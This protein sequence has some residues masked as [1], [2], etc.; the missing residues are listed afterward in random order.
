MP[1][2]QVNE[3]PRR[4]PGGLPALSRGDGQ[5]PA[6]GERLQQHLMGN[7][8]VLV[9]S[10]HRALEVLPGNLL[11]HCS[12]KGPFSGTSS[13]CMV[14]LAC[15]SCRACD[16]SSGL[17]CGIGIRLGSLHSLTWG[18]GSPRPQSP[19]RLP[20]GLV[21]HLP[22]PNPPVFS[23]DFYCTANAAAVSMLQ[24]TDGP[25]PC[26]SG[27]QTQAPQALLCHKA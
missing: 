14:P 21:P 17:P 20:R 16:G 24:A 12:R 15:S 22:L 4:T 19:P 27:A 18:V 10:V 3:V 2:H 1:G 7:H 26:E 8:E 23:K 5:R 25:D 9:P 13:T 11:F 6:L